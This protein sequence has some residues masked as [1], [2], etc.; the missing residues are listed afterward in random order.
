MTCSFCNKSVR[1]NIT[2]A[3]SHKFPSSYMTDDEYHWLVCTACGDIENK[4]THSLDDEGVCTICNLPI[5]STPGVVYDISADGPYAEVVGYT[6]TA[7][8]VKIAEE[9]NGLHVKVIYEKAF[10]NNDN[11][12]SVVIPDS[13]TSIG[14]YAFAYCP[15][16]RSVVIGDSV[17]SIGD[18]A[19]V[20]CPSL[21]SVVIG[22]GVTSVGVWAFYDC[23][24]LSSIVI[25][26]SVTN[27]GEYAFCSCSNL[28]S[29]IMGNSVTSIG[30]Y[31]F[32]DCTS[33]SSIVIP[34]SVTNIG[35]YA[36]YECYSLSSV[37]IGDSVT[38]IGD[39]AFANCYSLSSVVI[40]DSVTSIGRGAFS[41]C[42][43]S[44]CTEY[45]FGKYVRSGDNP[46]AVLI[47]V[48][49]KNMSSYTIHENTKVIAYG[50]FSDCSRLT[51]IT[52]PD[53]VTSISASAFAGCSSLK[54]VYY[55]GS[56]E[57]WKAIS[58]GRNNYDLTS[59]TKHYNYIPE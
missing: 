41:G 4:A 3:A 12:T 11:I 23:T 52:I 7:K 16:F 39:I 33:L 59:A 15:N 54:D 1:T 17:T 44:L 57:E 6:G 51:E 24:S 53:S 32:C 20:R 47:E 18:S 26:D 30:N 28:S 25:P 8:K 48:T 37:V 36:F 29:I 22:E 50:V 38:R 14:D 31:T 42:H 13:V 35:E 27:I 55:T 10:Y 34:D 58:I 19:F 56:E 46:Y 40:P 49:N 21:S 5:S 9:Y 43:S 2:E 45:E